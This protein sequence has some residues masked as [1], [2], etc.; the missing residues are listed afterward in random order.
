MTE[1]T[2]SRDREL[3]AR[4]MAAI[5]AAYTPGDLPAEVTLTDGRTVLVCRDE[6]HEM[7]RGRAGA[8]RRY[9]DELV[10]AGRKNALVTIGDPKDTRVPV[11]RTTVGQ[12]AAAGRSTAQVPAPP[13]SGPTP[14]PTAA[15]ANLPVLGQDRR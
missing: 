10:R 5:E 12:L 13:P 2:P 11:L 14:L 7:T 8:L 3:T 15:A 9:L 6:C 1:P 4:D